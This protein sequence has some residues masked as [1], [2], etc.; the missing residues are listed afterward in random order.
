M[1]YILSVFCHQ[2]TVESNKNNMQQI[3][4][5][6][7]VQ[8]KKVNDSLL[9]IRNN[10]PTMN[11]SSPQQHAASIANNA[12][13][14]SGAKR[15]GGKS[16]TQTGDYTAT[17]SFRSPTHSVNTAANVINSPKYESFAVASIDEIFIQCLQAAIRV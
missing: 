4:F 12:K 6:Q 5:I 13:D 9:S 2:K 15:N 16:Q 7:D 11:L 14:A 10:R 8:V 17:Q 1:F 3:S